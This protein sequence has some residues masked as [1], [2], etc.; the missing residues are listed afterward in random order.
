MDMMIVFLFVPLVIG[1][2]GQVAQ[3]LVLGST[4]PPKVAYKGWRGVY[5]VTIPAHAV[6]V[7]A[8]CGAV[9]FPLGVPVP[10]MFG[11]ALGGA[12]LAY[13]VAG[14]VSIVAYD[15]V[16]KVIRRAVEQTQLRG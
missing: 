12:V 10:Q 9:G 3:K 8:L 7:G 11:D 14:A 15:A 1:M 5:Y 16:I 2:L 13:A 4:N 6:L